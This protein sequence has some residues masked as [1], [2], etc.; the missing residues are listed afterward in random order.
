MLKAKEIHDKHLKAIALFRKCHNRYNNGV[1]SD[2]D[3][4]KLGMKI[5]IAFL[6][7]TTS[8]FFTERDIEEFCVLYWANFPN[9]TVLTKMHILKD[10]V[11]PG[12]ARIV[13]DLGSWVNR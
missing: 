10:H 3:M 7:V 8:T 1:V 2:E 9:T 12:F 6:V 11:I 5:Q 13:L 4:N